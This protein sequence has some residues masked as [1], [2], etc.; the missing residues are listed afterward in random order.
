MKRWKYLVEVNLGDV[1]QDK[2]MDDELEELGSSG[3]ELVSVTPVQ[4][5]AGG[6]NLLWVFKQ[7]AE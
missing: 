7:A 4:V 2:S 1:N 5:K 6:T 3:W